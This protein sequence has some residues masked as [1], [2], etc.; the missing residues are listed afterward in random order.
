MYQTLGLKATARCQFYFHYSIHNRWNF[1]W[2]F[3]S[4]CCQ[5]N[6][7]SSLPSCIII[8]KSL[9]I[10]QF[11]IFLVLF[12]LFYA[13]S[14]NFNSK[15]IKLEEFLKK[16]DGYKELSVITRLA[17]ILWQNSFIASWWLNFSS[18]YSTLNFLQI[19]LIIVGKTY[20]L[21]C[22]SLSL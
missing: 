9:K 8:D 19:T 3:Y 18:I 5:N 10:I 6:L 13:H 14:I 2:H 17:H 1:K 4:V 20:T 21:N 22:N 11:F 7:A 15:I 16:V 12:Q